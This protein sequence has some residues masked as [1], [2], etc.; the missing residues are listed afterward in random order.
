MKQSKKSAFSL[1]ELSIIILIIGVIVTGVMQGQHILSESRLKT[2]RSLTNSSIVASIPSLALWVESTL[3]DSFTSGEGGD[4]EDGD[5]LTQWL[6]INPQSLSKY[7]LTGTGTYREDVINGLPA[8][9]LNGSSDFFG[10]SGFPQVVDEVTIFAVVK[11]T[12][13][14]SGQYTLLSKGNH[15]AQ[16]MHLWVEGSVF[17]TCPN[18]VCYSSSSGVQNNK[19]HLISFRAAYD[20]STDGVEFYLDSYSPTG[21]HTLSAVSSNAA[22]LRIGTSSI[23]AG[24]FPGE[25]GEVIIFNEK[26]SSRD[27]KSVTKYLK[28]KWNLNISN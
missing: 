16:N 18:S 28:N 27:H 14:S 21:T 22:D 1:L 8:V 25:V 13:L 20:G 12:G 5:A 17:R 2:A 15:P 26:L 3:E 9:E 6:D 24:F 23:G 4:G 10:T 19:V 11:L 7:T